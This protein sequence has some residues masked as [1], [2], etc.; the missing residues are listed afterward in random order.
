MIKCD[1]HNELIMNIINRKKVE[2]HWNILHLSKFHLLFVNIYTITRTRTIRGMKEIHGMKHSET[3]D[4]AENLIDLLIQ[5][6]RFDKVESLMQEYEI[7]FE[8]SN[9]D[10]SDGG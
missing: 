8:D 1:I 7:D 2:K 5:Q 10:S 3:I 9:T 4:S 6:D